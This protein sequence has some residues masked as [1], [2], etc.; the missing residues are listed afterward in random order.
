MSRESI[1]RNKR[2]RIMGILVIGGLGVLFV[3]LKATI[4]R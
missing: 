3:L 2:I 1:E 4:W